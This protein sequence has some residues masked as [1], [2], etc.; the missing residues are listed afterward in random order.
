MGAEPLLVSSAISRRLADLL[1]T[2]PADTGP[3]TFQLRV[4]GI[5]DSLSDS[6][7][8]G[9]CSSLQVQVDLSILR[10]LCIISGALVLVSNAAE[11]MGALRC[12]AQA[13]AK[14][15]C[16]QPEQDAGSAPRAC[17]DF[18]YAAPCG[19]GAAVGGS[20]GGSAL[21]SPLLALNLGLS[22]W[23]EPFLSDPP[24]SGVEAASPA[25]ANVSPGPCRFRGRGAAITLE[26]FEGFDTHQGGGLSTKPRSVGSALRPFT[27]NNAAAT[28]RS[29]RI[30]K[31]GCPQ[32]RLLKLPLPAA[33]AAVDS[34]GS[35]QDAASSSGLGSAASSLD[36]SNLVVALEQFFKACP[37]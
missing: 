32:P 3:E 1:Q 14:P 12:V 10:R 22:T 36:S 31:V 33:A 11:G 18:L 2:S 26:P 5:V 27:A 19:K 28:A 6:S 23:L 21:V 37:R 29:I 13:I 7:S 34:G 16:G 9:P 30:V 8:V 17:A 35:Q 24:R 20:R 25:H 15:P 4:D